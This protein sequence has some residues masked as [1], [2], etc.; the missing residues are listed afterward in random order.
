MDQKISSI[1]DIKKILPHRYPFLLIDK[2]LSIS[3]QNLVALKNISINEPFFVGHFLQMAIMPGVL[4]IEAMAQASGILLSRTNDFD[5]KSD[6]GF[7]AHVD[8]AK[9][10]RPVVPGDQLKI[11]IDLVAYK[12]GVLKVMGQTTVDEKI[13]SSAKIT[14]VVKK[15]DYLE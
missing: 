12:R 8:D 5:P 11:N 7:L 14:I 6:I 3:D 2:V 9:F 4:Q 13:C 15:I 1:E 10:K